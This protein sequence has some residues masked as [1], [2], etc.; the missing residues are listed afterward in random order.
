MLSEWIKKAP[1]WVRAVVPLLVA[2]IAALYLCTSCGVV[3]RVNLEKRM[4]RETKD[5]TRLMISTTRTTM[6]SRER[7][8]ISRMAYGEAS[9][10]AIPLANAVSMSASTYVENSGHHRS[11]DECSPDL[12]KRSDEIARTN[13]VISPAGDFKPLRCGVN[14]IDPSKPSWRRGDGQP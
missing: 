1:K 5:T 8:F 9:S 6:R 2:A 11:S 12:A 10:V 14:K 7:T 4:V 3:Q 13:F